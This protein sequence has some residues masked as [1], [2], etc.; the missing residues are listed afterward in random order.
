MS[1]VVLASAAIALGAASVARAD[2]TLATKVKVPFSFMVNDV[3]L[4][5][6]DYVVNEI[7]GGAAVVEIASADR[8]HIAFAT[9]IPS[10]QPAPPNSPQLVFEK[11]GG[12]YFLSRIVPI[13]G[14][15]REIVLTPALM[16][17]EIMRS[18]EPAAN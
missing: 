6:G 10:N 3:R 4:P 1:A 16:A 2:E 8:R 12:A 15:D 17:R 18:G 7:S 9:T 5:A 11:F 13:G 14:N